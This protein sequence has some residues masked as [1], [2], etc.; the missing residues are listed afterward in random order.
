VLIVCVAR[1]ELLELRP[2]WG[3]GKMNAT[4]ILLEPLAGDDASRLVDNLLGRAEIPAIARERI[5]EAAEGNPLFVEEMLGMLIDDGL[6]RLE[7]ETWVATENLAE[8]TIPPT[9]QLLLAARLDRLDGEERAVIE[10]GSVEGKV[11]HTGAVATLTPESVRPNVRSRLLAL[12]RKELIRPDRAEFAGEDAFR[13]RHLMIR[14]AAYQSMPKEHRA[15][16]HERFAEWLAT[17]AGD[18]VD[19]YDEI[20]GHHLEQASQYRTELGAGDEETAPVRIRAAEYLMRA[21]DRANHR[22]DPGAAL[23][24]AGRATELARSTPLAVEAALLLA[25]ITMSGGDFSQARRVSD[26]A[27]KLAIDAGDRRAELLARLI[28]I[29]ARGQTDKTIGFAAMRAEAER[30]DAELATAGSEHDRRKATIVLGRFAFFEGQAGEARE[31]AERLL[32]DPAG[33]TPRERTTLAMALM[34]NGY[35]G[36]DP[37]EDT[38]ARVPRAL[39][40]LADSPVGEAIILRCRGALLGMLGRVDE[41]VTD[42]TRSQS[43]FD[44]LGGSFRGI[45]SSQMAGEAAHLRGDYEEAVRT[46]RRTH[47][48][49]NATGETGFNSTTSAL[50]ALSLFELGH[51][52][53]SAEMAE[54]SRSMASEDDFASQAEWRIAMALV[55][56]AR[57][58]HDEA[59]ELARAAGDFVEPTDYL[60]MKGHAQ[61]TFGRVLAAAER[62]EEARTAFEAALER[63]ERKGDVVS[64]ERVRGRLASL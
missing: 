45:M 46:H 58:N 30:I 35:F 38:L 21:A 41:S 63:Y 52:D 32:Q 13:F 60:P 49:F 6:L 5:L 36:S 55:M 29:E 10:R 48:Y 19:E 3:G 37:V 33:L 20:L 47:E 44:E 7:G 57:G 64:S 43:L 15:D 39:D 28:L 17:V 50:L 31:T 53:E 4:S 14:D 26:Q 22:A 24:L 16:L 51:V 18:R 23:G 11:F 27:R 2:G 42:L 1:P 34:G 62:P 59:I 8:V 61:E 9:I 56:S 25:E 12:A 40:A 54:R